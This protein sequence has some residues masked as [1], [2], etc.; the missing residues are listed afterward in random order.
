MQIGAVTD[1]LAKVDG[2]VGKTCRNAT[3]LVGVSALVRLSLR[4]AF[5]QMGKHRFAAFG[6]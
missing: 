4:C 6:R 5:L 2:V 3:S 1:P